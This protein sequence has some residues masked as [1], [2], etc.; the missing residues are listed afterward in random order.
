MSHRNGP[1]IQ[2]VDKPKFIAVPIK[3]ISQEEITTRRLV[4]LYIANVMAPELDART[5]YRCYDFIQEACWNTAKWNV[6]ASYKE[7]FNKTDPHLIMRFIKEE[8]EIYR[9]LTF[10]KQRGKF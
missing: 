1:T 2:Q 9:Q 7:F 3:E 4:N 8:L 5:P 10:Y 6:D